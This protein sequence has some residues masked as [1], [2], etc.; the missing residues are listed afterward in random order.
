MF[1][2][3]VIDEPLSCNDYVMLH[4]D[5]VTNN[6]CDRG[7]TCFVHVIVLDFISLLVCYFAHLPIQSKHGI[8]FS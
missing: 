7:V 2:G 1:H 8:G 5:Y 3:C 6:M 4:Q